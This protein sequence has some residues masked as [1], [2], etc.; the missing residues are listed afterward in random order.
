MVIGPGGP[1]LLTMTRQMPKSILTIGLA[2]HVDS[3]TSWGPTSRM[4]DPR[5]PPPYPAPPPP[6]PAPSG[7]H[8]SYTGYCVVAGIGDW[9]CA[10]GSGDGPNYVPVRVRVVGPDAFDLDAD[11]DGYGCDHLG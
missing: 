1:V 6:A 11:Y 5:T 10:G 7:C 2:H 8:S 4:P 3:P 9:D